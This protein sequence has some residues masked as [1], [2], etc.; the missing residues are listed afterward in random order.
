MPTT[1]LA[2]AQTPDQVTL[3]AGHYT[4][5]TTAAGGALGSL[6]HQGRDLVLPSGGEL[7]RP[8]YEG[9]VCA[10]WPNRVVDGRWES[11]AQQ[12]ELAITEPDRGHALHGFVHDRPWTLLEATTTTSLWGLD[13]QPQPGYPWALTLATAYELDAEGGLTWQVTAQQR[14]TGA[15]PTGPAPY[16]VT[17]HPYFVAGQGPAQDWTL[18]LPAESVLTV[19]DRLVPQELVPVGE[20]ALD[21]RGGRVLGEQQI[22]H[23]FGGLTERVARLTDPQG[24]GVEVTWSARHRWVQVF[25]AR[26][27]AR[28]PRHAVAIEPMT[29][30]PDA[31]NSHA[32]LIMLSEEPVT[33]GWQVRAL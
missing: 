7:G 6:Q 3:R 18:E 24:S 27:D 28:R 13:T 17:V 19:D 11:D 10:P 23:A 22:D 29:C 25:T 26:W 15:G 33:V 4:A 9:A 1:D 31:F 12:H 32:D 5:S 2:H 8:A 30:P 21:L 20:A 14:P 16:G